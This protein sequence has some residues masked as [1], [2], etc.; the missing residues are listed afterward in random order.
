MDRDTAIEWA[1][2][3]GNEQV[4]PFDSRFSFAGEIDNVEYM[5]VTRRAVFRKGYK[6]MDDADIT[7]F[8]EGERERVAREL[9]KE[10]G[11]GH[12]QFVTRLDSVNLEGYYVLY[13]KE[14]ISDCSNVQYCQYS[15]VALRKFPVTLRIR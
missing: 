14:S 2:R 9:L 10:E 8:K 7:Q 3:I 13:R 11:R 1:S 15:M 5:V 6:G 12:L 4:K